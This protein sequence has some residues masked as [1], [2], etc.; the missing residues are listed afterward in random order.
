MVG[1]A[2]INVE[3]S[4]AGI[5]ARSDGCS[6]DIAGWQL[7][8]RNSAG[9]DALM[10]T[11]PAET[12]I[13]DGER[14]L[15]SNYAAGES[16]LSVEPDF[17]TTAVSLPNTGLKLTLKDISGTIVDT[18]DDGS[19]TPF[20]GRSTEPKASMERID[21]FAP[22]TDAGNWRTAE[23]SQNFDVNVVVF[24]TPGV[25]EDPE[26]SEDPDDP[27]ASE[28][29]E[30][31]HSS[32]FPSST[33]SESSGSSE[34]FSSVFSFASTYSTIRITEVLPN[35]PGTDDR[36]WIELQN[37]STDT[38]D[39]EGWK[40]KRGSASYVFPR[41]TASGYLIEPGGFRI[42]YKFESGLSLPNDGGLVEILNGAGVPV[43]SFQYNGGGEGVS[44]GRDAAGGRNSYCVPTPLAVNDVIPFDPR[45]DIQSGL[46]TDYDR[47]TLNLNTTANTS[48]TD[49]RCLWDFG[50]DETSESC[51][52][53]SHTWDEYGVYHVTLKVM[54][55]C[56]EEVERGLDVVV[57]KKKEKI[58]TIQRTQTNQT[59]S[60]FFSD[61][62]SSGSSGSSYSSKPFLC[63]PSSSIGLIISSV[64]PSP[65]S[66]QDEWI[67]LTNTTATPLSLCGWSLDDIAD[68]GSKPW[69]FP[70][71]T[72][73]QPGESHKFFG[74]LT[75]IALNNSGDDVRLLNAAGEVVDVL[76]YKN[77][78]K[79]IV[80]YDSASSVSSS[81][82]S[83]KKLE[84]KN[85][86][87]TAVYPSLGAM[88][89]AMNVR[90]EASGFSSSA[91]LMTLEELPEE[92]R[93]VF[94]NQDVGGENQ[95]SKNSL[96]V[97]WVALAIQ[98]IG[99][100]LLA[101][102]RML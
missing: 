37:M 89:K 59:S 94:G 54:N 67:E 34:S 51:N 80:V 87:K 97:L 75:K 27:E 49:A 20:A 28:D 38:V 12:I 53:A 40:L 61:S 45:I 39:I 4:S 17:V 30:E 6:F 18:V 8:S 64:F 62:S 2:V 63:A 79:G 70:D 44:S 95:S 50:D 7:F 57:L 19:G 25:D 77:A 43:D 21:V 11:F 65:E 68:A 36:E 22:G 86:S 46:S 98:S 92:Y 16:A 88:V 78:K 81:L 69:K 84:Q 29:L 26:A 74:A 96:P 24:G 82:A 58:Q 91:S 9:E 72:D 90:Y 66:G 83:E 35:P 56:G 48:L 85:Y 3:N 73:L 14:I 32:L 102:W 93:E 10:F 5:P 76:R 33:S 42:F 31:G 99:F 100:V 60:S 23:V 47:V 101:F 71:A 55:A 15:V 13:G 41:L 52:P 1:D